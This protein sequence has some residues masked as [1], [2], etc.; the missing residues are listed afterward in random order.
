MVEVR[1]SKDGKP[2]LVF[3]PEDDASPILSCDLSISHHGDYVVAS[4]VA[5]L[6]T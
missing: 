2:Y 4:V 1:Y 3:A 5:L 6:R